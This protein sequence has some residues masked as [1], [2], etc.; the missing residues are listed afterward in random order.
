MKFNPCLLVVAFV[1]A[2]AIAAGADVTVTGEKFQLFNSS[3]ERYLEQ[4][5]ALEDTFGQVSGTFS[6]IEIQNYLTS[7]QHLKFKLGQCSYPCIAPRSPE[8]EEALGRC[9]KGELITVVGNL[10]KIYEKRTMETVRGKYTGGRSWEE[11]VYV[12]GPLQSEYYF[13]VIKIEKGWGKQDSPED[14]SAEGKNLTEEHYEQVSPETIV[15]DPLK[16]IERSIWFEGAYGGLNE[17][18]SEGEKAAGLTPEKVIKFSVE[19]MK[20]PC[21]VSKSGTNVE[22]FRSVP[23]GAKV[24]IYGRIR[25]K[26]TPKGLKSAFLV[27]RVT[28]TVPK[29]KLATPAAKAAN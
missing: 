12:Y 13:N 3:P 18:F 27:D 21:Y 22:G 23:V 9:M 2:A 16:L 17:S 20:T 10:Q 15:D 29:E 5:L 4:P 26:E 28:R 7:D 1:C 6:H 14:M 8:L 11:R 25:I 24:Q 19:G